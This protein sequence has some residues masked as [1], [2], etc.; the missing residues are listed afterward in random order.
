MIVEISQIIAIVTVVLLLIFSSLVLSLNKTKSKT[1]FF[2]STF[3]LSNSMYIAGYILNVSKSTLDI[4]IPILTDI[5]IGFGFLFGPSLYFLTYSITLKDYKFFPR[6]IWHFLPFIMYFFT[7]I[8][9]HE[10]HWMLVE[11][12]MNLQ[13]IHYMVACLNL[14]NNYRKKVANYFSS[15]EKISLSW[16]ILVTGGFLLM[17]LIDLATFI[18]IDIDTISY[19]V[20]QVLT[21]ISISINLLFVVVMFYKA[22]QSPQ[23]LVNI[24]EENK[25]EKYERSRLS[26]QEKENILNKTVHYFET[27]KPYLHP[28]LTIQDVAKAVGIHIRYISQVINE[29]LNTNFHDFVNSYRVGEAKDKLVNR[30]DRKKTILEIL[31]ESGFNSK[32]TFNIAFKKH[33]GITPSEYKRYKIS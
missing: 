28:T 27:E 30:T 32:T 2:L 9:Y 14:I 13:I 8:F 15:L 20:Y 11:W 18:L 10:I 4:S 6:N 24:I 26:K 17:W 31:Y 19:N 7:K 23:F 21:L 5:F 33:T 16:L 22:V 1:N 29:V 3:L 25:I 12:T